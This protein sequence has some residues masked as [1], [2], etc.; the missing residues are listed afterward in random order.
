MYEEIIKK[1]ACEKCEK[2]LAYPPVGKIFNVDT[3]DYKGNYWYYEC[4]DFIV[5]IHDIYV[6]RE[7]IIT[8]FPDLEDYFKMVSSYIVSGNGEWLSPYENISSNTMFF[9]DGT[10]EDYRFLLHGDF[11]Y[12][13]VGMRFKESFLKEYIVEKF[14]M[15]SEEIPKLFYETRELVTGEISKISKEIMNCK[16]DSP[17]ADIFFEAKAKEWIAIIMN[18]YLENKKKKSLSKEDNQALQKAENYINDHYAMDIRQDF[19][20]KIAQM[21]GTN[22]KTKF[23]EKNQMSITEYIQRKRINIGENLLLTTEL[24]IRDIAEAV[25]YNSHSRFSELY[26]RYKGISP[27]KVRK[28]QKEGENIKDCKKCKKIM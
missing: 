18:G 26:K 4:S 27:R 5:D 10:K 9:I 12:V 15:S 19:L 23:K 24:E 17:L 11:P 16:M 21:S 2:I 8:G 7:V 13:A 6:K 1:F 20:E 28:Y 22:L 14:N 25:G 3:E